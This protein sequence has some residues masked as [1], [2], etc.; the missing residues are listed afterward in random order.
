MKSVFEKTKGTHT[1]LMQ[2]VKD[3]FHQRDDMKMQM[4]DAFKAKEA[5]STGTNPF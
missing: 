4:G 3:A 1:A 5:V 2:K